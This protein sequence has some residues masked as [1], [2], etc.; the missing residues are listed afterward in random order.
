[1]EDHV[2]EVAV[3]DRLGAGRLGPGVIHLPL[4]LGHVTGV[5]VGGL[6]VAAEPASRGQ[7]RGGHGACGHGDQGGA[8]PHGQRRGAVRLDL[9]GGDAPGDGAQK[10][11]HLGALGSCEPGRGV[12]QPAVGVGDLDEAV[13]DELV[14]PGGRGAVGLQPRRQHGTQQVAVVADPS[15]GA[16]RPGGVAD[17]G[18]AVVESH[19]VAGG[20][21]V[22]DESA[23]ADVLV[24]I[25]GALST[26]GTVHA[27]E[28]SRAAPVLQT[29]A[30]DG[31]H[32]SAH[33]VGEDVGL[34]GQ[35]GAAAAVLESPLQPLVPGAVGA[36]GHGRGEH[37]GLTRAV[38][39][40]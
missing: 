13:N 28:G 3:I 38:L 24:I 8:T 40:Q 23:Q 17:D 18:R 39:S 15:P 20:H 27:V 5:E 34:G 30:G 22:G 2:V 11:G 36:D 4:L 21:D 26:D 9:G 10:L 7:D 1:M 25:D 29:V 16:G 32:H 35:V 19:L 12:A 33:G 31:E 14:D 37:D 6:L